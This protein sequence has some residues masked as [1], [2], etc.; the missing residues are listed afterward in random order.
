MEK[1]DVMVLY[2]DLVQGKRDDICYSEGYK[3]FED[4]YKEFK[5]NGA[6]IKRTLQPEPG[7]NM[8]RIVRDDENKEKEV[9]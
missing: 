3:V 2:R 7:Y 9:R 6:K 8:V 1:A 4:V 5:E